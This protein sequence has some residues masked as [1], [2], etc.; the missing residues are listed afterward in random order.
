MAILDPFAR[1]DRS[2]S[3]PPVMQEVLRLGPTTDDDFRQSTPVREWCINTA[4]VD[5]LTRSA[6]RHHEDGKL[7]RWDWS[8]G[9]SPTRWC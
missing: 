6:V 2:D 7:Y 9:R 5:P 1:L 4:A 8:P 3:G